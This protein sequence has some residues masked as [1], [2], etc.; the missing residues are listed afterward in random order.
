MKKLIVSFTV[1]AILAVTILVLYSIWGSEEA[2]ISLIFK[3][4]GSYFVII[5]SSFVTSKYINS[6]EK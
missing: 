3:A 1:I 2:N 5:I 6:I 4:L